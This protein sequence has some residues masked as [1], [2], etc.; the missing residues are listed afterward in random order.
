[1]T[2][3]VLSVGN[4]FPPLSAA[5]TATVVAPAP[6]ATDA[7]FTLRVANGSL[8]SSSMMVV[9]ADGFP[10]VALVGAD[11]LTRKDSS[12]SIRLSCRVRRSMPVEVLPAGMVTVCADVTAS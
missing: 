5:V 2:L 9:L 11:R 1:M 12:P 3:S 8:M 6:S 4:V 10:S 7:G